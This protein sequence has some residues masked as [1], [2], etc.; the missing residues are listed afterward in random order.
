M[1]REDS[2]AKS[3]DYGG[4]FC[5]SDRLPQVVGFPPKHVDEGF[6]EV[7]GSEGTAPKPQCSRAAR[8]MSSSGAACGSPNVGALCTVCSSTVRV[9][10]PGPSSAMASTGTRWCFVLRPKNPL[11]ITS[12]N[13]NSLSSST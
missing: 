8:C 7:H 5:T 4:H 13:C 1:A 3:L 12:T 6:S 10:E 2:S 9:I 11:M